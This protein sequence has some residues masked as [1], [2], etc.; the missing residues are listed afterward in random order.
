[1]GEC[2]NKDREELIIRPRTDKR[3]GGPKKFVMCSKWD[4][5]QPNVHSGMEMLEGILYENREN[6]RCFPKGSLISGCRRQKNLGEIVAPSKPVRVA[7]AQ[8]QDGCFPCNAPRACNLHQSGALQRVNFVCR[9]DGVRHFNRKTIECTTPNVTYYNLCPCR[10][11]SDY[12]GSTKNMKPRWS[13]HRYDIRN[14]NW[15][16]C[17]LTRHFGQYH[18][19][20]L[21][22]AIS[23][24]RVVLLDC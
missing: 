7:R 9:Y 12:V 15:T 20:D 16:A 8:V 21:E 10:N 17:G 4:P 3:R 5:R 22:T 11:A 2:R 19:G 14:S 1:M 18:T 23:S 24:L 13:K 6:E